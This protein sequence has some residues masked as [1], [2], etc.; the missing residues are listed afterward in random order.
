MV[1]VVVV[2]VSSYP[3]TVLILSG[4]YLWSAMIYPHQQGTRT[5]G[6]DTNPFRVLGGKCHEQNHVDRVR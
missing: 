2:V 1:V 4:Q 6:A 5:V 3:Q